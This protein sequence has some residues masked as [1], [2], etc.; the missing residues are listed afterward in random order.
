[1][2]IVIH[3]GNHLMSEAIYELLV[4]NGY[5]NVAI[6]GSPLTNGAIPHVLL[7]DISTLSHQLL[8]QYPGAE[9]L[10]IDTGMEPEHL[11]ATLLSYK[12]HGVLSPH[13]ELHLF[14]KAL[15]AISEG[16]L[17]IDDGTVKA[18]LHNGGNISQKGR[19]G[20]ITSRELE[21][22]ECICQGLS[23]REIARNLAVSEYTVK[24][25]LTNIFR[26]FNVTSRSK[27]IRLAVSSR[28]T[29]TA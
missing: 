14:R 8:A 20:H 24:T 27:L 28:R 16:Q 21:V 2:N 23:N 6:S 29:T 17:W 10:L 25:H 26:K 11:C 15:T 3:L 22:I 19:I 13:A 18:L 1:M 9:V 4:G 12:I 7:V 5:D